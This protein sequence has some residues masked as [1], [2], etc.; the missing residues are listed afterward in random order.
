MSK[1]HGG[2]TCQPFFSLEICT[3][4]HLSH[5]RSL[6]KMVPTCLERPRVQSLKL[7]LDKQI[8]TAWLSLDVA[9]QNIPWFFGNPSSGDLRCED[10]TLPLWLL[11][12][13]NQIMWWVLH[14]LLFQVLCSLCDTLRKCF[15]DSRKRFFGKLWVA[16]KSYLTASIHMSTGSCTWVCGG[17]AVR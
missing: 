11:H 1:K 8:L 16:P 13:Y 7:I 12:W 9:L 17:P 10:K 3:A 6:P 5:R 14:A 15:W 2:S 4:S